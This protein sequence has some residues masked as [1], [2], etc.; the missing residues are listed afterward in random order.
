MLFSTWGVVIRNNL[1]NHW[2]QRLIWNIIFCANIDKKKRK[3][4]KFY[5]CTSMTTS[6]DKDQLDMTLKLKTSYLIDLVINLFNTSIFFHYIEITKLLY[7]HVSSPLLYQDAGDSLRF[8]KPQESILTVSSDQILMWVVSDANYSFFMNLQVQRSTD[9][10]T[11]SV[12]HHAH[13][14]LVSCCILLYSSTD[15]SRVSS[16]TKK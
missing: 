9:H 11:L 7:T 10:H 6:S 5:T 12:S 14:Y 1:K 4:W 16:V 15:I 13:C 2:I 3:C 8:P